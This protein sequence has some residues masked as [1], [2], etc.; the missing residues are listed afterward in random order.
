[1]T[2][3]EKAAAMK[4][5]STRMASKPAVVR[6][7]AL[8]NIARALLAGQEDIFQANAQD[9]AEAA[10]NNVPE[11]VV[12]RL[13]FN[14]EKLT[15]TVK[16]IEELIDLPD[17][18]Y[19]TQFVRE[20]DEGLTLVRESCPIGVIG[21]IFEARPDALVQIAS[22][23]IKSGNCAIL[24]GGS[25]TRHTNK[26]LFSLI[27]KAAMESGLPENCLFQAEQRDEISEL[28]ACHDSVDLLIPRG[29]NAFVQYIMNNT[30]IPEIGRAH[31]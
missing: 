15:G 2:I 24:K 25:E 20:L 8:A 26:V 23:C 16:G 19:E 1:M 10:E 5:D 11:A 3:R 29:S 18:V 30:K 7:Q 6:N 14:A 22:L 31:V 17:R 13:K 28:L 9:M 21:V 12:K 27:Y 4:L